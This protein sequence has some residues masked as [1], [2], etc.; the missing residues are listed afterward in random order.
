M[1]PP[2]N[3]SPDEYEAIM[4]CFWTVKDRAENGTFLERREANRILTRLNPTG[5]YYRFIDELQKIIKR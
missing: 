4:D 3:I 1:I 2:P 5:N